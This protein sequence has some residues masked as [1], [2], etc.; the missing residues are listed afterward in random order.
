MGTTFA[1]RLYRNH[2]IFAQNFATISNKNFEA[3]SATQQHKMEYKVKIARNKYG[4]WAGNGH[5]TFARHL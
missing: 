3:T 4:F 1:H 2:G 5:Q